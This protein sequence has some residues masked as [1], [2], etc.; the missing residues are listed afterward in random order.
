MPT[1]ASIR[2][3]FEQLHRAYWLRRYCAY[4]N[5]QELDERFLQD[6]AID[7]AQLPQLPASVQA[8]HQYYF[9]K[10]EERDF[11]VVRLHR[12]PVGEQEVYII[13]VTTDGDDGWVEL[14][15]LE[16]Q[17]LSVGR[18]YLE[19]VGWGTRKTI[20][21]QTGTGKFPYA[22]SDRTT[23]TFW[24]SDASQICPPNH[25][26]EENNQL[27]GTFQFKNFIEA[28]SF[29]TEIAFHAE[30]MNHH[31]DWRNVWN[32]V[33]IALY[34]HDADNTV[35]EKDRKLATVIDQVYERYK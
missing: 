2:L 32:R 23:R 20:R 19:L 5:D 24:G 25:W 7:R 8:A 1:N 6:F 31:P 14:Y 13:Y 26:R 10:V 35:T 4:A 16:G 28:F 21:S 29:M 9:E 33:E 11:G 3:A 27:K 34:T 18:L 15:S 22:L 12:A 17:E 30:K